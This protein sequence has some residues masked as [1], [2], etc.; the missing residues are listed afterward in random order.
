MASLFYTDPSPLPRA[1]ESGIEAGVEL[2]PPGHDQVWRLDRSGL[3]IVSRSM[4]EDTDQYNQGRAYPDHRLL[5]LD[6][7]A[8]R[9][10]MLI[11]GVA[12]LY[13][14]LAI[15]DEGI[16]IGIRLDGCKGR[17]LVRRTSGWTNSYGYVSGVPT[18]Q[19]EL[20]YSI[21]TWMS[22][23]KALSIRFIEEI[24]ELFNWSYHPQL[25]AELL[26]FFD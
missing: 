17:E 1:T 19:K 25:S 13:S 6:K 12:K 18:V 24:C 21:E 26:A 23:K 5:D 9:I 4:Q 16:T 10:G 22:D 20:T 11:D 2:W 3:F 15:V 8:A 7:V 14:R